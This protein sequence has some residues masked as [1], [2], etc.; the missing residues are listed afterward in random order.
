MTMKNLPH[1]GQRIMKSALAVALCMIIYQIRTQLPVGNGIPFYSALAALW[2][3][4]PY[5]DTTKNNA[6]QRSFGTLTGAAY[7][8]AFLLLMRL[9]DVSQPIAVY[10]TASVL[11]IPVIYTTVVTDHR[12]A[13]FFSCVVF[14]SIALTHS[15]DENPFLF[16]LNRVIDT[17]IGIA[18]GVAVN[19]FR[20][21]IRHDNETLYVCGIDDV[22]ISAESQYS[23]VELNRLIR[24]G[25]K[26]T[27]STTRTPAELLS[28][29][30]GTELNLPVIVMDGAVLYDVK[31]K[32]YLE[33]VFLSPDVAAEAEQL[34]AECGLHCFVNVLLDTTLLIYYG[35]FRNYAEEQL[36]ESHKTS[37][38]RNYIHAQ[39]R[40]NDRTEKTIY[41][42]VLAEKSDILS[43]ESMLRAEL[44]G[45]VRI[46]VSQSEYDGF[47]YL[48]IFSPFATKQKMLNRL[49]AHTGAKK[50]VTF[51]SI[52]GQY[53]VYISDGG[54]NSTIKKLKK[55]YRGG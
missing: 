29:M 37:P 27:I 2:C 8:L 18:V 35:K 53:D 21:P 10:L 5:P 3:M 36:F 51:G 50:I 41:I 31:Q 32:K 40:R 49:K 23:K 39:Y 52:Q 55:L 42:T 7:G 20:F 1:I 26:F 6:W 45:R 15:F 11:V 16:V 43:L 13:S 46:S 17:F 33:T 19:D 38:Y 54:G 44:R 22:L 12:N 25:V 34:I 47:F 14:L 48:K 24:G 30:H 4:Q 9:F 28:L